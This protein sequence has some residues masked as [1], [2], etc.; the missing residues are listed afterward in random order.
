MS[1]IGR[2]MYL[3]AFWT[4]DTFY[5]DAYI[6]EIPEIIRDRRAK[7]SSPRHTITRE[8][9]ARLQKAARRFIAEE[10]ERSATP[11]LSEEREDYGTFSQL[12]AGLQAFLKAWDSDARMRFIDCA[13]DMAATSMRPDAFRQT[14][15]TLAMAVEA[16]APTLEL[17]VKRLDDPVNGRPAHRAS[18]HTFIA[19]LAGI[20]KTITGQDAGLSLAASGA[21][22]G[23]FLRFVQHCLR[24]LAPHEAESSYLGGIIK[25][26][27]AKR[28]KRSSAPE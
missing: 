25:D 27:L 5:S 10:F 6:G 9:A 7:Q 28:R 8:V 15:E 17:T 11:L 26:A 18:L 14:L 3:N 2:D 1:S 24:P 16:L 22:I 12:L 23:P 20:Y 19:D 13:G 4:E 21:W